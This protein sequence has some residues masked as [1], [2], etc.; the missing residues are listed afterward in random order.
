MRTALVTLATLALLLLASSTTL[1]QDQ[2]R[3][4]EWMY[5]G[6]HAEF[7]E[8]TNLGPAPV[9]L[10][11]WSLDDQSGTP[12]TL[13]LSF[14]GVLAPGESALITEGDSALFAAEWGLAGVKILG[15]NQVAKLGRNDSIHLFDA[16]PQLHDMFSYGDE[17]FPGTLR[18]LN[19]S[20]NACSEVL[21][22]DYVWSWRASFL[23]DGRGTL[24]SASGDVGNPGTYVPLD[25]A[26]HPYC[27]PSVPNSSSESGRIQA[28][29]SLTASDN[30]LTLTAWQLPPDKSGYFLV[31]QTQGF[32]ATPPGS[33]GNLCL[34]GTIGRYAKLIQDSGPGGTFSIQVDLTAIPT[35]PPSS[36]MAGDTW[37]F[38]AWFRDTN[39]GA[40]SNFT[41]AL[42][43]TFE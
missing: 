43:I 12:G 32:V 20:G 29:G 14:L 23:G 10:T 2:V 21:G 19:V 15:G 39:P 17:D 31:S 40:T 18:A 16:Q 24:V 27:S 22:I 36:V 11:G 3:I 42:S 4:T 8:I 28:T 6:L 5:R 7:L 13:D 30:D 35:H 33:Q 9:D 1:A 25:C 26:L 41:D 34:G 37:N 38:Q